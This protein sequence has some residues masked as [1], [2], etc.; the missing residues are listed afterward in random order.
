MAYKNEYTQIANGNV[1]PLPSAD[2]KDG[3]IDA[4][5]GSVNITGTATDFQ[6]DVT[7]GDYL[8]ANSEVRKVISVS[9]DYNVTGIDATGNSIK[10][11]EQLL[12]IDSAFGAPLVAADFDVI[13]KDIRKLSIS[14]PSTDFFTVDGVTVDAGDTINIDREG[15][16]GVADSFIDPIVVDTTNAASFARALII[17]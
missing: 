11:Y 8:F 7:P 4:A 12:V 14:N 1:V 9:Q 13:K 16:N 3:T 6:S 2:T 10:V 15:P 17:K 5:A